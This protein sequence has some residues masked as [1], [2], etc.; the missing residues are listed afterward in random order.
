MSDTDDDDRSRTLLSKADEFLRRRRSATGGAPTEQATPVAA[1]DDLPVLTDVVTN[2]QPGAP[3]KPQ[4]VS[5]HIAREMDAW[6]DQNLSLAVLRALDG[7]SDKLIAQIHD[8]AHAELLPRI[9]R[10]L[11]DRSKPE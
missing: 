8:S 1:E 4:D 2:A 9:R 7:I 10:A 3:A 5:A 6:L 11:R